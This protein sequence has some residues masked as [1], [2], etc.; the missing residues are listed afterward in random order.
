MGGASGMAGGGQE[1]A[2]PC[3]GTGSL[4]DLDIPDC[5]VQGTLPWQPNFGRNRRKSHKNGHNFTCM[6]HRPITAEFGFDRAF[7]LSAYSPMT[8]PYT[9]DKGALPLQPILELNLLQM[10][11]CLWE[12][13]RMWRLLI[14][15]SFRSQPI[16]EDIPN[17][18]GLRD[19][20]MANK[21]WR[22]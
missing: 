4:R 20:A 11:F 9:R 13:T 12:I 10:P 6:W 14:T 16:K 15:E 5:R 2:A 17:C 21:F 18:N 1:A 3:P 19:V 8:L 7:Q 22:K